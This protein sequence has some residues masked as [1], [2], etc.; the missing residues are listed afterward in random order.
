MHS[1][2]VKNQ[3]VVVVGLGLTGRSCVR[4]LQ[5]QGAI[6]SVMDSNPNASIPAN[7]RGIVG[8]LDA[9]VLSRANMIVLSPGVNPN[10]NEIQQAKK[11]G[12]DVIGDVELFARVN[13]IPVI[14]ITG[15]NGKSTVTSLVTDMLNSAGKNAVMGGNIGTPVLDLVD[16]E[17][18]FLVLELSSFQLE[19]LSSLAPVCATILNIS[20]DHLDRH[21]KLDAYVQAKSRIYLNAKHKI[22]NRDDKL[23]WPEVFDEEQSFGLSTTQKGWQYDLNMDAILHRGERFIEQHACGIK[24]LHNMLNIQAALAC[25]EHLQLDTAALRDAIHAFKG[26]AHRFEFVGQPKNVTWINDSKATNVGATIAAIESLVDKKS[27][28]LV[29]IAGGDGKN[30]DFS[31]LQP[32]LLS[33][34]DLLITLGK[35]GRQIAA[36]KPGSVEVSDLK[37]AVKLAYSL[38]QSGDTVLLS[39]ACASIDMFDNYQQRGDT[40]KQALLE[41][42]S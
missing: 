18:D 42:A 41:I 16:I 27:G 25:V 28:K 39:P 14:A 26:L 30:A 21:L 34:V 5:Q 15:S 7:T 29:L 35:D 11:C 33:A 8:R 1:L 22:A 31:E 24:G 9:E 12:V 2:D 37:E 6:V 20:E 36:L 3:H 23:T 10:V 32:L 19:T 17:A 40:F 38:A 4:F 13:T